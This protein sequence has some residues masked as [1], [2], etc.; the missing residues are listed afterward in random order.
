MP[1]DD[2]LK[3][4]KDG[5]FM[6]K[7]QIAGAIIDRCDRCGALWFDASELKKILADKSAV[8]ALDQGGA[9]K[10]S[11]SSSGTLGAGDARRGSRQLTC[12]RDG[13]TLKTVADQ[14][15]V[16]IQVDRCSICLGVLLDA[17]ELKDMSEFRLSERLRQFFGG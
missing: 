14:S 4:P 12:P 16:H 5:S 6:D 1:A 8:Q 10:A 7:A 17:G 9:D 11:R 15:Q 3:C 13:Q 2:R